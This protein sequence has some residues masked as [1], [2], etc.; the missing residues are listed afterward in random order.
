MILIYHSHSLLFNFISKYW[1]IAGCIQVS[2]AGW[3]PRV[4][5]HSSGGAH[6]HLVEWL[7]ECSTWRGTE[8]SS[9]TT[10]WTASSAK[11]IASSSSTGTPSSSTLISYKEKGNDNLILN[12]I[13]WS[14]IGFSNLSSSC[15]FFT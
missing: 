9:P 3:C 14:I 4:F 6:V 13:T 5:A 7:M 1:I 2:I 11:T 12:K 10:E 15:I 8:S